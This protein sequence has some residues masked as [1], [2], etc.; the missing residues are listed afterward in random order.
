MGVGKNFPLSCFFYF[1]RLS[2]GEVVVQGIHIIDIV[3]FPG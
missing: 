1:P 2:T 3:G